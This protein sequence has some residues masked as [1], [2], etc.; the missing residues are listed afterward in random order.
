MKQDL[1]QT[2]VETLGGR[3]RHTRGISDTGLRCSLTPLDFE[4]WKLRV[5]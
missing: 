2:L 4:L 1:F 5:C 3:L